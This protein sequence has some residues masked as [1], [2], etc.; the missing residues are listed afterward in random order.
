M[1]QMAAAAHFLR[2]RS[3]VAII[4]AGGGGDVLTA[5]AFQQKPVIGIEMNKDIVKALTDEYGA[6]TGHLDR[7]PGFQIVNDEGR[8]YLA[9]SDQ[10]FDII[11]A[12]MIDT[13]AATAAGAFA[14]S[15]NSLY[16]V[17]AWRTFLDRLSPRG[18]LSFTRW[19]S[20]KVPGEMYRLMS[21]AVRSLREEGASDP[22]HHIAILRR[23]LRGTIIVSKQPLTEVDLDRLEELQEN[24]PW[25]LVHSPRRSDDPVFEEIARAQSA[26][27]LLARF[28]ID[29]T[30][31]TD[32]RPFFFNMLKFGEKPT[33]DVMARWGMPT[34][35]ANMEAVLILRTLTVAIAGV[36][37][38]LIVLPLLLTIRRVSLGGAMP[39]LAYFAAIGLAFMLVEISQLQRLTI[40]L[41]HPTYSLSVVL[42]SLLLSSGLGSLST[43][44]IQ[45]SAPLMA[46]LGRMAVLLLLLS[47]FGAATPSALHWL[48][49]AGMPLRIAVSVLIL[50]PMGFFMGMAFPIGMKFA[51]RHSESLT[52]WLWGVNGA[53]SVFASVLAV[54][55]S[56]AVGIS[57]AFWVGSACY[58]LAA[59]S[60]LLMGRSRSEHLLH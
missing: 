60:L 48:R 57:A 49:G 17:E 44:G 6:F 1:N 8:S 4:G 32:D 31:P 12:R 23:Q 13:W 53:T 47:I 2:P 36:V 33:A 29:I 34:I 52:P 16:T 20:G 5:H 28:P 54:V 37:L 51:A 21:L 7:L 41:G 27:D 42:F 55:I 3:S 30:A 18:I 39:L 40:F 11:M 14:L 50:F 38:L 35:S 45:D 15:E 56:L 22:F 43:A 24:R 58:L 46:S 25:D 10:E 19:Y 59:G 9:R 26:E